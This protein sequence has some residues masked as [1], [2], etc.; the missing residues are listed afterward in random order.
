MHLQSHLMLLVCVVS[1]V[2]SSRECVRS[3]FSQRETVAADISSVVR[4]EVQ[5]RCSCNIA[6][7][8]RC[9]GVGCLT[10]MPTRVAAALLCKARSDAPVRRLALIWFAF[11]RALCK[12]EQSFADVVGRQGCTFVT[13]GNE[14]RIFGSSWEAAYAV[15]DSF[16]VSDS[17]PS[18][19]FCL[20]SVV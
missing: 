4:N 15:S 12:E 9:A 14:V 1:F 16:L 17:R 18:V 13:L 3:L 8:C 10:N 11:C 20:V 7:N 19:H 2:W 5:G 6:H